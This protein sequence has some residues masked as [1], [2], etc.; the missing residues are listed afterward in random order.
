MT[1]LRVPAGQV[2]LWRLLS[3]NNRVLARSAS[4]F[5]EH[6]SAVS[7]ARAVFGA[8]GGLDGVVVRLSATSW[9]WVASLDARP[10]AVSGRSYERRRAA[11]S[12]LVCFEGTLARGVDATALTRRRS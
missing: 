1:P 11:Q 10:V 2:F 7:A 12:A 4:L 3:A 9:R 6:A 8:A 5:R